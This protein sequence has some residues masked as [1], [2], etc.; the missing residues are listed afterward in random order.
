M[1]KLLPY[2]GIAVILT[3]IYLI[4]LHALPIY[5]YLLPFL[6]TLM[7]LDVYLWL[8]INKIV[9]SFSRAIRWSILL[10]YWSPP[11][12]MISL[13]I[14]GFITPFANWNILL[15]TYLLAWIFM[16]YICKAVPILFLAI[17]DVAR[18]SVA[19][20]RNGV[21]GV[22]SHVSRRSLKLL[23]S[24]WILG[25]FGFLILISGILFGTYHFRIHDETI[26]LPELPQKF[27]GI[28]IV[29]ISDVHLGSW[30]C[31]GKLEKAIETINELHPDII[32]FTGDIVNYTSAEIYQF[33][34]ILHKLKASEGIFAI[35]GNHDYGDY[36]EWPDEAAKHRNMEYLYAMYE[37]LGW[38]LLLNNHACIKR[39]D[40]SI[41]VI[42]VHNWGRSKRFQRL[43]SLSQAIKGV[44]KMPVQLLLSHDPSHWE[45]AVTKDFPTID[46][47]FS[48]HT[49]GFQVGIECCGIKWSPAKYMMTYW[50]GLYS[51]PVKGAHPQYLY[52]NRGLGVIGYPGRIG[53][54]PEITLITLKK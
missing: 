36:V 34:K 28:R 48:G 19:I 31:K 32:L 40:D 37:Y 33:A 9:Q 27:D 10:I 12:A 13:I 45:Y 17:L 38:K 15:R 18:F 49:H 25:G 26:H 39:G 35:L 6:V 42:G 30:T 20:F 50:A 53:I 4:L 2:A 54:F 52:V 24:G 23:K 22:R 44:E 46:I 16:I 43:G 14:A 5:A 8:S 3:A 51:N 1:R 47:T 7:A 21:H 11:L 29:Q 41:A